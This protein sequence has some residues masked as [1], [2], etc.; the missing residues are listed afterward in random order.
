MSM[1]SPKIPV[2]VV[3]R[4]TE[5]PLKGS[6]SGRLATTL[7]EMFD[8]PKIMAILPY[9]RIQNDAANAMNLVRI[10]EIGEEYAAD[11]TQTIK[12]TLPC[13]EDEAEDLLQALREH[14]YEVEVIQATQVDHTKRKTLYIKE[15]PQEQ[16][17]L[18]DEVVVEEIQIDCEIVNDDL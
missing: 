13:K 5:N 17:P 14:G 9:A 15:N 1:I 7:K 12:D 4:K 18:F 10:M 6:V 3:L 8:K 16:D 11:W 2:Q